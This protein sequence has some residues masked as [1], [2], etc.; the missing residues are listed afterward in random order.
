MLLTAG[1]AAQAP[2]NTFVLDKSV[3]VPGG[4]LKA[5]SY[6]VAVLDSLSDRTVLRLDGENGKRHVLLLGVSNAPLSG[7]AGQPVLWDSKAQGKRALRGFVLS[8]GRSVELVYPKADAVA[9]AKANHQSVVAVDTASEGRPELDKLSD[10]DMQM[11]NLWLLTPTRVG[12]DNGLEAKRFEPNGRV[13]AAQTNVTPVSRPS[14]YVSSGSASVA[15][16]AR[17]VQIA[18]TEPAPHLRPQST[19]TTGRRVARLPQTGS[20]LP[21]FYVVS[22]TALLGAAMI[23]LRRRRN[24]G[25]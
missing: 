8:D 10:R 15:A 1:M 21:L 22:T 19:T 20:N 9:L 13:Q 5:G 23:N 24:V 25:V 18:R 17:P 3:E 4:T 12:P 7:T 2:T 11:V 16:P 6:T 14:S